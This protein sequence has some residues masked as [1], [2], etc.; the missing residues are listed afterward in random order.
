MFAFGRWGG[1]ILFV[2]FPGTVGGG[3]ACKH[4][5]LQSLG[6][7]PQCGLRYQVSVV[8]GKGRGVL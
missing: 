7:L 3:Q 5:E 2:V 8:P 4:F 1:G 6:V